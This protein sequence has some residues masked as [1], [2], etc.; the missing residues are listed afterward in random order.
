MGRQMEGSA[1]LE[2]LVSERYG[3]LLSYARLLL[4][5]RADAEDVV[6]EALI[7]TFSRTRRFDSIEACEGYVRRAV[8]TRA[9]D[10]HRRRGRERKALVSLRSDALET[11]ASPEQS[12]VDVTS[13]T[14]ALATLSPRERACVTLRFVD[15]LSVAETASVLSLAPGTV[16]RYVSDGIAKLNEQLGT[17]QQLEELDAIDVVSTGGAR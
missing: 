1:M 7:A 12:V 9:I 6:H 11:Q 15:H 8:A 16:K 4:P 10:E 17:S 5:E 14:K 2:R 3:R 13:L